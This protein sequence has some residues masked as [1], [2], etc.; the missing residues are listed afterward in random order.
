MTAEP[1]I[2]HFKI[3]KEEHCFLL[4]GSDGVF[5]VLQEREIGKI[6]W[7]TF[8]R[9]AKEGASISAKNID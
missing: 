7:N 5:D 6:I 3:N 2:R 4:I 8:K 9:E 1:E